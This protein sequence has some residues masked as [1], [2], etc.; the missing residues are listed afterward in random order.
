[1]LL[2]ITK[3][4]DFIFIIGHSN[5]SYVAINQSYI[6]FTGKISQN[7]NTSYVA[8]NLRPNFFAGKQNYNSNTSYV[9]I[10]L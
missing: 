6:E 1:M 9:A 10:N 5:T 3:P 2:L 8:I 4:I 7:S